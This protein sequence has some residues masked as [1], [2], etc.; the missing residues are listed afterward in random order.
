[1][2]RKMRHV[3][4]NFSSFSLFS[5]NPFAHEPMLTRMIF[6]LSDRVIRYYTRVQES[7]DELVG[8]LYEIKDALKLRGNRRLRQRSQK[9]NGCNW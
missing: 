2:P 3:I 7:A 5:L 8:L 6:L 9:N 4:P 1:M